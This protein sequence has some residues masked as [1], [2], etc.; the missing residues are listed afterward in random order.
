MKIPS[1][2]NAHN[3]WNITQI[4]VSQHDLYINNLKK[5]LKD[6]YNAIIEDIHSN[7]S[8]IGL[9]QYN[10]SKEE[11]QAMHMMLILNDNIIL[12]EENH[13]AKYIY[14]NE[15]MKASYGLKAFNLNWLNDNISQFL[16]KKYKLFNS[17]I[18]KDIGFILNT[19]I[20]YA[21]YHKSS[22]S[23]QNIFNIFTLAKQLFMPL[24]QFLIALTVL[25]MHKIID[26][27]LVDH[28]FNYK[29]KFCEYITNYIN[30][31]LKQINDL[32]IINNE[33]L[34]FIN[35][36]D[37][38][39]EILT[40]INYIKNHCNNGYIL[41][42]FSEISDNNYKIRLKNLIY[43]HSHIIF[44]PHNFE[45]N[46]KIIYEYQYIDDVN[47]KYKNFSDYCIFRFV[48]QRI[49]KVLSQLWIK[50]GIQ[51]DFINT[52]LL[53]DICFKKLNYEKYDKFN[54]NIF[55]QL[56]MTDYSDFINILNV[57][58]STQLVDIA[59][60]RMANKMLSFNIKLK[61]NYSNLIYDDLLN[62]LDANIQTSVNQIIQFHSSDII[63]TSATADKVLIN[64]NIDN[65]KNIDNTNDNKNINND[66]N[67]NINNDEVKEIKKIKN[68]KVGNI[69]MSILN[70][71]DV[72]ALQKQNQQL[73]ADNS[74][75]LTT[76]SKLR[77]F[78]NK[79]IEQIKNNLLNQISILIN[80]ILKELM[81][82]NNN[83]INL[84]NSQKNIIK[85]ILNLEKQ[86]NESFN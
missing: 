81:P 46:K 27:Q 13:Y 12:Q 28:D 43:H 11:T 54:S 62:I 5:S 3:C 30:N 39:L 66:D 85:L 56:G 63:N 83:D 50:Y 36:S 15:N 55:K 22:I 29:F 49:V 1:I 9:S 26:F 20:G 7:N 37:N 6:K 82:L 72:Q 67:K 69:T 18:Y 10:L 24:D 53:L 68:E 32:D 47:K 14:V 78:H 84:I 42:S 21:Y 2:A 25:R 65:N 34:L 51:V 58:S 40:Y 33:E 57:L 79:D 70:D 8:I 86:I 41:L 76:I 48:P 16:Y 19:L 38:K 64:N 45:S 77:K 44:Q 60:L 80:D 35:N 74:E 17:K 61:N 23:N 75:L 71:N 31:Q 4:D 73:I 52:M 59:N